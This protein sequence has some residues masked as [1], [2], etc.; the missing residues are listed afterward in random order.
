[1]GLE[2]CI[3]QNVIKVTKSYYPL[4]SQDLNRTTDPERSILPLD[5]N[6][7]LLT[8][9]PNILTPAL[10][11]AVNVIQPSFIYPP[12]TPIRSLPLNFNLTSPLDPLALATPLDD[13]VGLIEQEFESEY[14][15]FSGENLTNNKV[16]G[17]TVRNSLKT[18]ERETGNRSVILYILSFDTHL[19]L[20]LVVP[21][22]PPIRRIVPDA[23]ATRVRQTIR[24]LREKIVDSED[25][26]GY[27]EYSQE[28]YQWMIEPFATTLEQL[29]I[30]TLIF[31]MD[32][33]LR[34]FPLAA[35]H[36]G[37]Q[38]LV[39]QYSLGMI[40]SMSLTDVRYR[41]LD[42]LSVLAMGASTFDILPPLPAVPIELD[43]VANHVWEGES[44]LNEDFTLSN[45]DQKREQTGARI[46]HLATH[47][48][49]HS[50]DP[51]KSFLQLWDQ[52]LKIQ[53]LHQ[54]N[55]NVFPS[56]ELLVLSACQTASGNID[57][58]LGFAGLSVQAGV[59]SALASLWYVSDAGTLALKA[60]LTTEFLHKAG[61][62]KTAKNS[63]KIN[64]Q[65]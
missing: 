23:T 38:F 40:P 5:E 53:D 45:L 16:N 24:F 25:K 8:I 51:S 39:E 21:D 34:T 27:L 29:N 14:E 46:L 50:S 18:I 33:G 64:S 41:D 52:S 17:A 13:L 26:T 65:N 59:K 28:L 58:E 19:D 49:F 22:G 54:L 3:R 60:P 2:I 43:T 9:R 4:M 7:R 42:G 61:K 11:T 30:D 35:L 48:D 55:W 56:I 32:A 20:V 57:A 6:D 63:M 36:N 62:E 37:N 44:Y 47:A 15:A 31:S 1:M 12:T 10:E